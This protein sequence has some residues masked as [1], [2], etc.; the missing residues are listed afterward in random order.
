MRILISL[1]MVLLFVTTSTAALVP[2]I[3]VLPNT[4]VEVGEEIYFDATDTTADDAGQ[5]ARAR[6]E[7]DFDDGYYLRWDPNNNLITRSGIATTHYFMTDRK[8]VV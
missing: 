8:S 3:T 7:W 5:L 1:V 2:N 6:H 4:T